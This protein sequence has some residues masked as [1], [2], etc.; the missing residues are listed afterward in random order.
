MKMADRELIYDE[1]FKVY[2][3]RAQF[4]STDGT[5][6][7]SETWYA[8]FYLDGKQRSKALGVR[9]RLHAIKEAQKLADSLASGDLRVRY[10]D[11]LSE[12]LPSACLR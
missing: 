3:G 7:F 9:T 4:R 10:A 8:E 5:L 2:I 6:K 11:G 1:A 12:K